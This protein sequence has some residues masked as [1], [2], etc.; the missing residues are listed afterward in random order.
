M[1]TEAMNDS[2][3]QKFKEFMN[4]DF[5]NELVAEHL[6]QSVGYCVMEIDELNDRATRSELPSHLKEDMADQIIAINFLTKAYHYYSGDYKFKPK[7]YHAG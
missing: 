4:G 1:M 2:L 5:T 3:Y 6:K 7:Y